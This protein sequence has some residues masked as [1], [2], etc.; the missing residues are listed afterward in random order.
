MYTEKNAA[1]TPHRF[2]DL[3]RV[4][5]GRV[6]GPGDAGWDEVRR[7]WNVAV[8]Q[9]PL[10]VVE[11]A[12][13]EDV[14]HAVRWAADHDRQ[15]TAQP[16]GHGA[17]DHLDQVLLLRTR[18][19]NDIKID[20]AARTATVG[21]GVKA[22][23][24]LAALSGTGLTFLAGSS[25]DPTVVGMT[26]GGGMSWFGR[27]YGQAANAIEAVELVDG[28]GRAREVTRA[29]DPELFWALR[30]G[31]GDFGIVTSLRIRLFPAREIYGGQLMWPA[32]RLAAV[33]TAFREI[34]ADAPDTLTLWLHRLQFPP[35]PELPE[36]LRGNTFVTVSLTHLGSATEAESLIAPLR[37]IPGPVLGQL[38]P[39]ALEDLGQ[40]ASEPVH[41]MPT[42]QHS[43]LLGDLGEDVIDGIVEQVGADSGSP[44]MMLKV[45]H[46]GGAFS[47]VSEL[48][49]AS[50]EIAEP[51]LLFAL[52]V[53]RSPDAAAAIGGAFG[54]LQARLR[55]H[56]LGRTVPNFMGAGHDLDQVWPAGVRGKLAEIKRRVDPMYT[57]RSNRP[58]L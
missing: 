14:R 30:G 31:G 45:M 36:A 24:L 9:R 27:R 6:H 20:L 29:S 7:P 57:I 3:R 2:D 58:V 8:E 4:V 10:A 56:T 43:F 38:G 1:R 23:E 55:D 12:D 44:L 22:G 16:V 5:A 40:V 35:L 11:V 50:G 47:R 21:A 42:M 17:R 19:L 18:A 52:G 49:G 53:P 51:Y 37:A 33:L 15:V 32:T 28:M 34:T 54:R 13:A 48:A 46:L 41:P 25:P 26:L 39:V